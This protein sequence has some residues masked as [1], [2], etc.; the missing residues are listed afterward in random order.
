V[1]VVHDSQLPFERRGID[2]DLTPL[3]V[4]ADLL[5]YTEAEWEKLTAV[6]GRFGRALAEEV[7]WVIGAA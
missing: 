2:W 6:G 4:P 1:A 5:V 3:P 7:V